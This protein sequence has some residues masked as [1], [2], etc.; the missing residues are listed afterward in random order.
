VA[1]ASASFEFLGHFLRM[2]LNPSLGGQ[3]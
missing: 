2:I 3:L 1:C